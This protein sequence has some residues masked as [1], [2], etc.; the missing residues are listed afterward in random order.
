VLDLVDGP[1]GYDAMANEV[2]SHTMQVQ[3]IVHQALYIMQHIVRHQA[4][5]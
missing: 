1:Y 4:L 3:H 2:G 5:Y